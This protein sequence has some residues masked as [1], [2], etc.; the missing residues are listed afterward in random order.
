MTNWK[1]T[2]SGIL[3]I[4]GALGDLATMASSG[5][6]DGQHLLTDI[7]LIGAGSVGLFAKD[8]NVSNAAAP[9]AA[10]PVP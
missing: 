3:P 6:W 7:G 10:K 1:T 2:L 9:V 4:V 5:N 8:H